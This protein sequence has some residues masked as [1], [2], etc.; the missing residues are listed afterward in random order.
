[1]KARDLLKGQN[2]IVFDLEIKREIGEIFEGKAVTWNT[3]DLMGISVGVAFDYLK[4][5]FDVFMFDNLPDLIHRLNS[6]DLITGFNIDG[7]DIPLLRA[8]PGLPALNVILPTWDMLYWSRRAM[9]WTPDKFFPKNM[10]LDNH[11]IGT[12]GHHEV[13]TASGAE[14]PQMYKAKQIGRLVSYCIA[15]VRR[16]RDL[17]ESMIDTGVATTD[18]HGSH[19]IEHHPIIKS[20]LRESKIHKP[21]P[22]APEIAFPAC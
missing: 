4:M 16:E 12:F 6:A 11:L 21:L 22:E 17:F 2:I 13:K 8:T 19:E 15:D 18:T 9:G 14:A 10:K 1:M 5:D 20:L 3:K 7:F